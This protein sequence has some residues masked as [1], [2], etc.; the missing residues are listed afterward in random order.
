M[1]RTNDEFMSEVLRRGSELKARERRRKRTLLAVV[2]SVFLVA[3]ASFILL[4]DYFAEKSVDNA[5]D[6]FADEHEIEYENRYEYEYAAPDGA[7]EQKVIT[8]EVDRKGYIE[9]KSYKEK[10][11]VESIV[12]AVNAVIDADAGDDASDKSKSA[13]TKSLDYTIR[14]FGNE[15]ELTEYILTSK[16]LYICSEQRTVELSAEDRKRIMQAIQD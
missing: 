13:G 2:P 16:G 12:T 14:F 3:L 10:T 15:G 11:K 8:V 6:G 4:P 5:S 1:R 7:V 9:P